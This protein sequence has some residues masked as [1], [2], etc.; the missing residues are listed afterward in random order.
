MSKKLI[1]ASQSEGRKKLLQEAGFKF[2]V[3]VSHFDED[4]IRDSD[5]R[6]LQLTHRH[7]FFRMVY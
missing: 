6:E 3:I 5:P 7:Q 4:S 1:L 2:T